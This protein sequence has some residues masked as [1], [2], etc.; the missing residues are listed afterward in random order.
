MEALFVRNM[1]SM[2][3]G[4][5]RQLQQ[6]SAGVDVA[7]FRHDLFLNK[8]D[9]SKQ[10]GPD[11]PFPIYLFQ[12]LYRGVPRTAEKYN[13]FPKMEALPRDP[14]HDPRANIIN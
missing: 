13:L 14:D 1:D 7:V 4:Y 8:G 9:G 6:L 10:R 12:L 3:S 5:T 2:R 11:L